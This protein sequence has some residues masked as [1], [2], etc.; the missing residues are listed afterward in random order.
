VPDHK[1]VLTN[2][3]P[4]L[5]AG[6][7]YDAGRAHIPCSQVPSYAGAQG[8]SALLATSPTQLAS[9]STTRVNVA[10]K[11]DG[12]CELA[13]LPEVDERGMVSARSRIDAGATGTPAEPYGCQA[14]VALMS[15]V[16]APEGAG[17]ALS[18]PRSAVSSLPSMQVAAQVLGRRVASK[19]QV[20]TR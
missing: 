19:V 13:V 17:S 9:A 8:L 3:A 11:Q 18:S 1:G 10:G 12:A 14:A 15:A 5:P 7:L 4:R 20:D 16:T 6:R 2:E